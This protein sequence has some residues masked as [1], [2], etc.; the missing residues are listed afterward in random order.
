[1]QA[2]AIGGA[3]GRPPR[4]RCSAPGATGDLM[5]LAVSDPSTP[6]ASRPARPGG[7]DAAGFVGGIEAPHPHAAA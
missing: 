6:R 1:M 2:T 3:A 7:T 4:R 5:G